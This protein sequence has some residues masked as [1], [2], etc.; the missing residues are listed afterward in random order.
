M[1][2][3]PYQISHVHALSS[4]SGMERIPMGRVRGKASSFGPLKPT[5]STAP[6]PSIESSQSKVTQARPQ[7]SEPK[8]I[9]EEFSVERFML[10][11]FFAC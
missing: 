6:E 10:P 1:S 5:E 8:E 11:L 9:L 3:A 7:E 2:Q 4:A